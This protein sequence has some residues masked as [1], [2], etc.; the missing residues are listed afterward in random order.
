VRLLGPDRIDIKLYRDQARAS[1]RGTAAPVRPT[2]QDRNRILRRALRAQQ[3]REQRRAARA[4]RADPVE[5]IAHRRLW[6]EA[7]GARPASGRTGRDP[8][9]DDIESERR[10]IRYIQT[11]DRAW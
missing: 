1:A 9:R 3:A 2:A 7:P 10:G 4:Y 8:L 5:E 11:R 6:R